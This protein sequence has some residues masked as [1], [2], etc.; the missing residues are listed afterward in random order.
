MSPEFTQAAA[1]VTTSHILIVVE[2]ETYKHISLQLDN[3]KKILVWMFLTCSNSGPDIISNERF[4]V[5][6]LAPPTVT[7]Q[8][9]V[10][11]FLIDSEKWMLKFRGQRSSH[12]NVSVGRSISH[13]SAVMFVAVFRLF[14]VSVWVCVRGCSW[15]FA[16]VCS[17]SSFRRG[18]I[19]LDW[20]AAAET[21]F[22]QVV[23]IISLLLSS[24]SIL[25]FFDLLGS[26]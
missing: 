9:V 12:S 16:S 22:S 5:C 13:L 23:W 19:F 15:A 18:S 7:Q 10:I 11:C 17:S 2:N 6:S 20:S 4:N 14:H 26:P 24:S 25:S 21:G 3:Y 8:R 1:P